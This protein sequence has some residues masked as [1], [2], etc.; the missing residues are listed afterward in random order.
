MASTIV[1]GYDDQGPAL[2]ALEKAAEKAQA[3]GAS[4]LVVAVAEMPLDPTTPPSFGTLGD[5]STPV[6]F[7]E[8]PDITA[9]FEHAREVVSRHGLEAEYRWAPGDPASVLVTAAQQRKAELIVIGDHH[10][11]FFARVFGAS[12]A[13]E[14]QRKAGCDVLVVP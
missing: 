3:S 9:A 8:P 7:P 14:V 10:H 4:L 12:I 13:P 5:G 6:D 1:V 2:R 11:G